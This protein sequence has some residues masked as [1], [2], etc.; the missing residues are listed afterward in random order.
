LKH[1]GAVTCACEHTSVC[2]RT[3]RSD[4]TRELNGCN[5]AVHCV[6]CCARITKGSREMH[7]APGPGGDVV[8][9][10][11]A[12][13]HT[14]RETKSLPIKQYSEGFTL[15]QVLGPLRGL[16]VL[17]VACGDGYYTRG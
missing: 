17:D 4:S 11:D 13:A 12:I 1:N 15:F 2:V 16:A 8:T 5:A 14:Y 3:A 9:D 6:Q 7:G 10:Y